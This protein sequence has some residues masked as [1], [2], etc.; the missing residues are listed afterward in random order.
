[1]PSA[2]EQSCFPPLQQVNLQGLIYCVQKWVFS[3]Q[4]QWQ[5]LIWWKSGF[6]WKS[7]KGSRTSIRY[8]KQIQEWCFSRLDYSP[9]K[10]FGRFSHV[11]RFN[12]P[13]IILE[14]LLWIHSS[15]FVSLLYWEAQYGHRNPGALP[16][17][18][19]EGKNSL[20]STA[21]NALSEVHVSI[22]KRVF[23]YFSGYLWI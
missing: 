14:E 10:S 12:H 1:M 15:M 19:V 13:L 20:L 16:Q 4:I 23:C 6:V 17:C 8:E 5:L 3:L 18:W 11:V 7:C 2:T 21:G 22:F 9:I